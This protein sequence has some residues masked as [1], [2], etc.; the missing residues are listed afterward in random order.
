MAKE[1]TKKNPIVLP[2]KPRRQRSPPLWLNQSYTTCSNLPF[3]DVRPF[4]SKVSSIS[5]P[6]GF[7]PSA[8]RRDA[9]SGPVVVRRSRGSSDKSS[10]EAGVGVGAIE[11]CACKFTH[12]PVDII[13]LR[14][15][16]HHARCFITEA[17]GQL[18][19]D[20]MKPLAKKNTGVMNWMEYYVSSCGHTHLCIEIAICQRTGEQQVHGGYI[21]II[22]SIYSRHR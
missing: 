22:P 2:L 11:S 3:S 20:Q 9:S 8:E 18:L 15:F 13:G 5:F 16:I 21:L 19:A 6:P 12:K 14:C 7:E 10:G 4:E 1:V 17:P